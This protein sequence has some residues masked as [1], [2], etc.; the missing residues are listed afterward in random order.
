MAALEYL[1]EMLVISQNYCRQHFSDGQIF[2]GDVSSECHFFKYCVGD[3]L[4]S[5]LAKF[6][7]TNTKTENSN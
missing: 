6:K 4:F 3:R 1:I 5:T 2:S 7:D